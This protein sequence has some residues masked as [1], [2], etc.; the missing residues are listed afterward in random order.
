MN[1]PEFRLMTTNPTRDNNTDKSDLLSLLCVIERL[2]EI[3][4]IVMN[5]HS[6]AAIFLSIAV[7]VQTLLT[8]FCA[9]RQ[10]W[11][12]HL[13]FKEA[14]LVDFV[15]WSKRIEQ[16]ADSIKTIDGR[17]CMDPNNTIPSDHCLYDLYEQSL[18]ASKGYSDKNDMTDP[19]QL[20]QHYTLMQKELSSQRK[21][22]IDSI[23]QLVSKKIVDSYHLDIS[24]LEDLEAIRTL[25]SNLL[26]ELSQELFQLHEQQVKIFSSDD[27]ER[28]ADRILLENEYDGQT[29]RREARD[30]MHDWRNGV[31]AGKL[32]ESRKTQIEQTKEEIRK[33]RY[34]VKL[35]Q[36]VNLD[37]DFL[38]Q[39]SEF[40]KFLFNRRRDITRAELR[41]LIRLVYCVYYYQ[42]DAEYEAEQQTGVTESSD[43]SAVEVKSVLP[44]DF[45]QSF[46]DS[47]AA[48][49]LFYNILCRVEPY[50]NKGGAAISNGTPELCDRYKDW[51]WY[52]LKT[53]FE[54][55][56]FLPKNA[57]KAPF[58]RFIH[59]LF[60]HR[61]EGS[62]SRSLHRNTNV[63]SPNIVADVVKEFQPVHSLVKK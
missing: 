11:T 18:Q 5:N 12:I 36:Y 19:K 27:Y 51:T 49:M 13:P 31:P 45:Q 62:V 38:S 8:K 29:A 23:S 6:V 48:V 10:R 2:Y 52:H 21:K 57:S 32:E 20:L 53:A 56:D 7:E 50:I 55:L 33:T 42:K 14:C 54:Q 28:L 15:D 25:C 43:A 35:E 59:Q 39:R 3:S 58:A 16:M 63:N 60:P 22:C 4:R 24:V 30:I 41:E 17:Y 26:A 47:G 44:T 61:T 40:G 46:R 34:G 37:A 9:M 1:N